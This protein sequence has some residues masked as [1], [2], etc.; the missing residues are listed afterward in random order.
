MRNNW[1]GL[2]IIKMFTSWTVSMCVQYKNTSPIMMLRNE[3]VTTL[4]YVALEI[5]EPNSQHI[6][7]RL[8]PAREASQWIGSK[9]AKLIYIVGTYR[10]YGL[11][12]N[13]FVRSVYKASRAEYIKYFYTFYYKLVR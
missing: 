1:L 7:L 11:F 6:N 4:P 13:S 12:T 3:L 5:L 8:S 9:V 10:Y 2:S